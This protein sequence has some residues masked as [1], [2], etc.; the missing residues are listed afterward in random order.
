[1]EGLVRY[2]YSVSPLSFLVKLFHMT[3]VYG[4]GKLFTVL[5][6]VHA[7]LKIGGRRILEPLDPLNLVSYVCTMFISIETFWRQLV[8]VLT[9]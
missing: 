8:Q 1:M 4:V 7:R 9:L 2:I 5:A 6:C 3:K